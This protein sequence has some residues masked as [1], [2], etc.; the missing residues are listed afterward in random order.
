MNDKEDINYFFDMILDVMENLSK[1]FLTE[2]EE[3]RVCPASLRWRIY[4]DQNYSPNNAGKTSR[5]NPLSL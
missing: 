5:E 1:I 4:A 2:V 3:A